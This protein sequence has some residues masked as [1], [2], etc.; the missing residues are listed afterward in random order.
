MIPPFQHVGLIGK[1]ASN[2]LGGILATLADFFRG[3]GARVYLDLATAE[4][5][6]SPIEGCEVVD[7]DTLGERC[8]VAVVVGGDGTLLNAARSLV[9][10]RVPLIGINTGR[11]GF[12]VDISPD[13]MLDKL[14]EIMDGRAITDERLLLQA[15]TWR[16]EVVI[17]RC[18][19]FNDA[20]VHK[21]GD[22]RMLEFEL[23]I[24]GHFVNRQRADGVILAT[25]TGST[26]Y[27]LSCG[28]PILQPGQ[29]SLVLTPICP[30]TL[31]QRPVVIPARGKVEVVI[32]EQGHGNA[33]ITCDGQIAMT[34][35]GGDRVVIEPYARRIC[36]IH[37]EDYDYYAVLRAKLGWG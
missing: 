27:A 6:D 26:A 31:S 37:P 20:V 2:E 28:G 29:E 18:V 21:A 10:H 25:P 9:D 35:N 34:L 23:R 17:G 1:F 16:D 14:E 24:D 32:S 19:A 36:L 30:H 13:R 11:L 15:T 22:P 33:Q 4:L 3:R 12:L 7:R 5:L 8:D